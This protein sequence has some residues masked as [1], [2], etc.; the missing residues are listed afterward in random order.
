MEKEL[1]ENEEIIEKTEE[2][3]EIQNS[4]EAEASVVE[5]TEEAPVEDEIPADEAVAHVEEEIQVAE[6]PEAQNYVEEREDPFK[7]R[8]EANSIPIKKSFK[9][10]WNKA[11]ALILLV[12]FG[13]PLAIIAYILIVFFLM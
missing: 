9:E 1:L 8:E 5:A 6:V 10:I 12:A 13:I 3:E 11:S 4:E 7:L 2:T